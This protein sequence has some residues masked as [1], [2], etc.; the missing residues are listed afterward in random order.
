MK[1]II[2]WLKK[3]FVKKCC[4]NCYWYDKTENPPCWYG[5]VNEKIPNFKCLEYQYDYHK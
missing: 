4:K 3:P 5:C 1:K 2:N